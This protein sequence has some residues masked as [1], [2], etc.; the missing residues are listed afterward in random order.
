MSRGLD[1]FTVTEDNSDVGGWLFSSNGTVILDM[2][3]HD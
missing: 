1:I 2:T 3:N